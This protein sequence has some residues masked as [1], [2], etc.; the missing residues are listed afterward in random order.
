MP[1]EDDLR[2]RIVREPRLDLGA[3]DEVARVREA[4][5]GDLRGLGQDREV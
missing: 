1:A 2:P 5:R 3:V 4:G